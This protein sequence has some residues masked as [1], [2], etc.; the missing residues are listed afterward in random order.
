VTLFENFPVATIIWVI[1]AIVYQQF[2]NHVIQPQ[3]QKRT[4]HVQ[5]IITIVAVLFGATLLGVVGALVAIPVAA[6]IQILIRE[7][8]DLRT[9][10][11]KP[12]PHDPPPAPPPP[13]PPPGVPPPG[14]AP[15]NT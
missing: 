12:E 9:L 13:T 15:A 5:P 4:V 3:I 1:W 11:I 7:Y 6:S 10:S 8:V 14:P 2:E